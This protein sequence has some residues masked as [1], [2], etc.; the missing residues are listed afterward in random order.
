MQE[1]NAKSGVYRWTNQINGKE[2]I[3]SAVR[4]SERLS[5]YYSEKNMKTQLKKEKVLFIALY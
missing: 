3:G 4:L 2:Y 1:N 5:K